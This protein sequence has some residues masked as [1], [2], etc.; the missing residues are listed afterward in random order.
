MKV[1]K[2]S[3]ILSALISFFLITSVYS[4]DREVSPDNNIDNQTESGETTENLEYPESPN[5]YDTAP[6]DNS[7]QMPNIYTAPEQE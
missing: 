6:M 7:E 5:D 1:F 2:I 3:F 4:Q